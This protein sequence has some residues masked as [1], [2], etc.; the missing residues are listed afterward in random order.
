[1]S[2]KRQNQNTSDKF[3][4][5]TRSTFYKKNAPGPAKG[6]PSHFKSPFRDVIVKTADASKKN[7]D[8]DQRMTKMYKEAVM[9]FHTFETRNEKQDYVL[10]GVKK[11]G[12]RFNW[13]RLVTNDGEDEFR[14]QLKA[15]IGEKCWNKKGDD[16]PMGI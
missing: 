15:I 7:A 16:N 3:A 8:H 1:D 10:E 5:Q 14:E 12:D 9:R 11:C 13:N 6:T 2:R 4:K